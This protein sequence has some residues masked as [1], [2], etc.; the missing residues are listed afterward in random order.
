MCD[1]GKHRSADRA[2]TGDQT[3]QEVQPCGDLRLRARPTELILISEISSRKG[4][5]TRQS[6]EWGTLP[7][8]G[9]RGGPPLE[10]LTDTQRSGEHRVVSPR[11]GIEEHP[12]AVERRGRSR[13]ADSRFR[14]GERPVPQIGP[15]PV[16]F[17]QCSP[18]SLGGF[19]DPRQR[20]Q[21]RQQVA[22]SDI[23]H[24]PSR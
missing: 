6:L 8:P 12:A 14:C 19:S 21:R 1:S 15:V 10:R 16:C 3:C 18:R 4:M 17:T 22:I 23:G 2:S 5:Q 9:Q 24:R 20:E 7:H 13:A 11:G